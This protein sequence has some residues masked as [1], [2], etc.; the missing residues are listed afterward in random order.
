[1]LFRSFAKYQAPYSGGSVHGLALFC[2]DL[3]K[4]K[5]KKYPYKLFDKRGNG[6]N[7]RF[8]FAI[9]VSVNAGM[10]TCKWDGACQNWD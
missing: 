2:M 1:M 7:P 10:D 3:I 9:I 6:R 8:F 4:Q 5:Y